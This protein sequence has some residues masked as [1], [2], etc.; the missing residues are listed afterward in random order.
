MYKLYI[1]TALITLLRVYIIRFLQT[2]ALSPQFIKQWQHHELRRKGK[3]L[4]EHTIVFILQF[5]Q[6]MSGS[7]LSGMWMFRTQ[8]MPITPYL[9]DGQLCELAYCLLSD[10]TQQNN[11]IL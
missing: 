3:S 9:V 7:H 1:V 8:R 2:F 6:A 11:I 5:I 4:Q 10:Y